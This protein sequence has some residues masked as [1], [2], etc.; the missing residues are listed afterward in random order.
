MPDSKRKASGL[1]HEYA[2]EQAVQK[3]K[4][5]QQQKIQSEHTPPKSKKKRIDFER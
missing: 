3:L 2:D 4:R 5:A 1:L